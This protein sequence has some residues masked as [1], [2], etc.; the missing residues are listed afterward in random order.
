[1]N[2]QVEGKLLSTYLLKPPYMNFFPPFY[3]NI[4]HH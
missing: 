4:T 2:C 1:M 3:L